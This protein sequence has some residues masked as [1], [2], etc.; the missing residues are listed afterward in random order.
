M[1]QPFDRRWTNKDNQIFDNT[2]IRKVCDCSF[3]TSFGFLYNEKKFKWAKVSKLAQMGLSMKS[4]S[5]TAI[6]LRC[7]HGGS[8]KGPVPMRVCKDAR[9][10]T[11]VNKKETLQ[12]SSPNP[13]DAEFC[14]KEEKLLDL[15][16]IM[17][18]LK[19]P[20]MGVLKKA[21]NEHAKIKKLLIGPKKKKYSV[22]DCMGEMKHTDSNETH[23]VYLLDNTDPMS[24]NDKI[25]K[26][27]SLLAKCKVPKKSLRPEWCYDKNYPIDGH[28]AKCSLT[29]DDKIHL[30]TKGKDRHSNP[31]ART[32]DFGLKRVDCRSYSGAVKKTLRFLNRMHNHF[33][34]NPFY[35]F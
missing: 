35:C 17:K 8:K 29:V 22:N 6:Y 15:A 32:K 24:W 12:I 23:P 19:S 9:K 33:A 5:E 14:T 28:L 3:N 11:R 27:K 20:K 10:I 34:K 16:K 21:T 30:I 31:S 7:K 26:K 25:L 13:S 18:P 4:E 1:D 2:L